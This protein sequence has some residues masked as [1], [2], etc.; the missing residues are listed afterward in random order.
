MI[1]MIIPLAI[2]L[3]LVALL[4]VSLDTADQRKLVAS[5]L[6]GRPVPNF[7]LPGLHDP[8]VLRS[9]SDLQGEPYIINVWG[10]WCWACREEHPYI[11]RLGNEAGIPLVG[12]NWKDERQDALRWLNQFGDAWSFHMVDFEGRAAIDL[13]V[14]GAPETFLVDHEGIIRHKH[15]GPVNQTVFEDLMRRIMEMRSEAES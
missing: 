14:Y 6:I 1:R 5:P 13:G 15:I 9:S 10:S 7:T 8:D 12:F 2:F 3:G 4:L 11:E